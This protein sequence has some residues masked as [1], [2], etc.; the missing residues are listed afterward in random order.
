MKSL[1]KIMKQS[2]KKNPRKAVHK[3]NKI[4]KILEKHP[5]RSPLPPKRQTEP[6]ALLEMSPTTGIP[7]VYIK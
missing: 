6:V 4:R 7:R 1:L 5:R 3:I 2:L